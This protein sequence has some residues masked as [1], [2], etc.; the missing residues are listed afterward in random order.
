MERIAIDVQ[1]ALCVASV[2]LVKHF[3][4]HKAGA[5]VYDP[6]LSQV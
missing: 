2:E 6:R 4:I 1:N 5:F 3:N